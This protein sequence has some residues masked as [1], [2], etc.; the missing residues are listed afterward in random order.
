MRGVEPVDPEDI[1][2]HYAEQLRI[3]G[4][5]E[6][7]VRQL[8]TVESKFE[9]FLEQEGISVNE[10][11]VQEVKRFI[12]KEKQSVTDESV[13][14]YVRALN[15]MV[16]YYCN[17]GYFDANP[18]KIAIDETEWNVDNRKHRKELSLKQLRSG[19]QS[20]TRPVTFTELI[21]LAKTGARAAEVSNLDWADIHIT[22]PLSDRLFPEPR[23]EIQDYPDTLFIDSTISEGDEVRG[24]VRTSGNK[25]KV[26]SKIPIDNELKDTLVW[27]KAM[28]PPSK[29]PANPILTQDGGGGK[30]SLGERLS[31]E[32][33]SSRATMWARERG[34]NPKG[35]GIEQSISSHWFRHFFTTHMTRRIDPDDI[36]GNSPREIVKFY[37][38]DVGED[39][40]DRYTHHWGNYTRSAYLNN[41]YKLL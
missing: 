36:E 3:E 24:E 8:R 13:L 34:W 21:L 33:V 41:I 5:S 30:S 9:T 10:V 23:G 22:H 26:D 7:T 2:D 1:Y 32:S 28:Q 14:G 39:I 37:R 11:G 6:R 20:E 38:G 29:S 15:S 27:W 40:I 12:N 17:R 16:D 4:K 31:S 25:R 19:I 35:T 18:V